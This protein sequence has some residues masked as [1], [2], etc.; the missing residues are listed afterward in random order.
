MSHPHKGVRP[1]SQSAI[2]LRHCQL[3]LPPPMS[4][5]SGVGDA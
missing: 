2:R 3:R 4:F 5:R 1:K